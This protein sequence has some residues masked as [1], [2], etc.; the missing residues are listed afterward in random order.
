MDQASW[1]V[2]QAL[3]NRCASSKKSALTR[4][5]STKQQQELHKVS[6]APVDL[7]HHPYAIEKEVGRVH[8][9]WIAPFLRTLAESEIRLCLASLEETQALEIEKILLLSHQN[10]TLSPLGKRFCQKVVWQHLKGDAELPSSCLPDSSLHFLLD[11]S[12]GRLQKGIFFLG[13]R[14]LSQEIR[15][16]IDTSRL[17][18]IET[19]LQ[20][21]ETL[22]FKSLLKKKEPLAFKK[23]S[24]SQWDGTAE[25]L[26]HTLKGR[27]L[28]RLAKSCEG[29]HPSFLFYI[30]RKLEVEIGNQFLALCTPLEPSK[31]K[32]T[33]VEQVQEVFSYLETCKA[34]KSA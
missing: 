27:G 6:P 17:K 5:L 15:H 29:Q 30:S 13:L 7:A 11:L 16:I 20:P 33:L 23:L 31:A 3:L 18:R 2:C 25:T 34:G 28:N 1:V 10:P 4:C 9:T 24:L 26:R 14:D 19:S 32:E 22:Y 21:D 12:F 8:P